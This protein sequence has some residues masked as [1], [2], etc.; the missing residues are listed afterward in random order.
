MKTPLFTKILLVVVGLCLLLTV[1]HIAYAVY[2][3]QHG[4]II[5]FIAEELW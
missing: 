2:A 1:A 3:Y 5:Y 4:S